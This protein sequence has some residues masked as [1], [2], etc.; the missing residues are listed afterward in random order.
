M[1][2]VAS[3]GPRPDIDKIHEEIEDYKTTVKT[4]QAF[5]G[6]VTWKDG[7]RIPDSRYSL[8]RRMDTSDNNVIAPNTTVTP[9]AVIQ[10]SEDVGFVVEAKKTLPAN[11]EYWE[12][13][14][15][16]LRKYDDDSIGWWTLNERILE[17][18]V[19]LLIH[20]PLSRKFSSFV[21]S[22]L[23]EEPNLFHGK[24]CFVDFGRTLDVKEFLLLRSEWGDVGDS[25]VAEKLRVGVSVPMEE[26]VVSYGTWKFYDSPPPTE[27][28]ME[29]L[30]QHI[31]T[32]MK[33]E[34]EF[35]EA[36]RCWPLYVNVE[37]LTR[38]VQDLFGS[39]G[40]EP[41]EVEYP[42]RDW[43]KLALEALVRLELAKPKENGEYIVLFRELRGDVI[44]RF[45]R[46]RTKRAKQ[47]GPDVVQPRLF[48]D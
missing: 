40:G 1:S 14:V 9:D 34:A 8:G 47:E 4:L 13:V 39:Q 30:W 29:V 21:D 45:A 16:Q 43:V 41:R 23:S 10:R 33:S 36:S 3:D 17:S 46:Q 25:E 7:T 44:E 15:D 6:L 48:D 42:Q 24:V 2:T 19:V 26:L 20:S 37:D 27:Y 18:S 35:D 11:Q 31:F 5:V 38:D 32:P 22:R 12:G 28:L